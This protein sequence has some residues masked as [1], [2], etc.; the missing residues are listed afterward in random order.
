MAQVES[1]PKGRRSRPIS[2]FCWPAGATMRARGKQTAK[3]AG[4]GGSLDDDIPPR[5]A[6]ARGEF[7]PR[8]VFLTWLTWLA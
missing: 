5:H 7:R 4:S 6:S 2:H 3:E 1:G 8:M